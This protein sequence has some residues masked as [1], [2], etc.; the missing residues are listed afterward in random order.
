[1][2]RRSSNATIAQATHVIAALNA[3]H[4]KDEKAIVAYEA[5]LQHA[6][7][8]ADAPPAARPSS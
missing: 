7:G 8:R 5:Q 2:K 4:H 1:M 6:A 3:E